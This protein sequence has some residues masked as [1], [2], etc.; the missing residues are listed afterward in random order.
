MALKEIEATKNGITV[1]RDTKTALNASKMREVMKNKSSDEEDNEEQIPIHPSLPAK[2][3]FDLPS[4]TRLFDG[5]A[6]G[7]VYSTELDYTSKIANITSL[8]ALF[9]DPSEKVIKRFYDSP[10][11]KE[12]YVG[13][14]DKTVLDKDARSS[15]ESTDFKLD[16]DFDKYIAEKVKTGLAELNAG[17]LL[18]MSPHKIIIYGPGDFFSE[19]MDSCHT[20]GQ[21]MSCVVELVSEYETEDDTGGL[22]VNGKDVMEGHDLE[23]PSLCVFYHDLPHRVPKI[24]LGYRVSITFDLVVEPPKFDINFKEDLDKMKELGVTRFGFFASHR[25]LGNNQPLKGT[26]DKIVK[27]VTPY[28]RSVRRIVMGCYENGW[29]HEKLNDLMSDAARGLLWDVNDNEEDEGDEGNGKDEV[30]NQYS[31]L[32]FPKEFEK[33]YEQGRYDMI[34]DEYRYGDVFV[35]WTPWS[36]NQTHTSNEEIRLGNEGFYGEICENTFILFEI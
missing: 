21:N 10:N 31:K 19:H 24:E 4:I 5:G 7:G 8:G 11:F 33:R 32:S 23:K 3:G 26:D 35:C 14:G 16:D 13:K 27:G 29:M 15:R 28:T 2:M 9:T 30:Q 22:I 1:G 17:E 34:K 36:D 12:S 25:Y 20:P 18:I 6:F